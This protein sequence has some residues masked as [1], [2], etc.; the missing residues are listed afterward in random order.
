MEI[1]KEKL[2]SVCPEVNT[3]TREWIYCISILQICK[4]TF[5][6]ENIDY[7][8]GRIFGGMSS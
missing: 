2:T 8:V 1:I 3:A 6:E 5:A 4:K 7:D